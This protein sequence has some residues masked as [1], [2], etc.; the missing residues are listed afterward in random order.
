LPAGVPAFAFGLSVP[1]VV[2]IVAAGFAESDG[3]VGAFAGDLVVEENDGSDATL[4][5]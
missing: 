1:G 4:A 2:V 3:R 5:A